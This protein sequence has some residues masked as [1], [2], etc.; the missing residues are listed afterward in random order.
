[1]KVITNADQEIYPSANLAKAFEQIVEAIDFCRRVVGIAPATPIDV[2]LA[3]T[4]PS[5]ILSQT[6]ATHR[7]QIRNS[8]NVRVLGWPENGYQT[9]VTVQG[10]DLLI[11]LCASDG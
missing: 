7:D 11:R 4:S 6:I 2:G 5:G 1:M 3:R 10:E 9:H 8:C